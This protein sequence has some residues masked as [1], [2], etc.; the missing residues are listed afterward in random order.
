[1]SKKLLL[2]MLTAA[3]VAMA[4]P[5]MASA[6]DVPD[7]PSGVDQAYL[8]DGNGDPQNGTL[9]LTGQLVLSGALTVTCDYDVSIDYFDDGT[10]AVT[11]FDASNCVASLPTCAVS[12]SA[13]DLDW[14]DR[15]G[16]NT[17]TDEYEDHINVAFNVTLSGGSCPVSGT[18]THHGRWWPKI[19]ITG[20]LI[21]LVWTF[22]SSGSV[23]SAFGTA[24]TSGT[25]TGAIPSG[26][27]LIR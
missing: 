26:Y 27:Q 19:R 25:L 16:F 4:A 11:Q 23:T 1:M 20:L 12:V 6:T 8:A 13:T 5:T 2:A 24:T 3:A 21:E 10:T 7:L 18:F 9:D 15:F 14:G 17:D 22:G